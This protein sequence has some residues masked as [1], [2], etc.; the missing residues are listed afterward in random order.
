MLICGL[1]T[2]KQMYQYIDKDGIEHYTDKRPAADQEFK[3][4]PLRMPAAKPVAVRQV[5]SEDEPAWLMRNN[6]AGPIEV[7]LILEE[8]KAVVSQPELPAS[9][10]LMA[11]QEDT[12]LELFADGSGERWIFRWNYQVIPGDPGIVPNSSAVNYIPFP[13]GQAYWVSQA[14]QGQQTHL[15]KQ[16]KFA[17]DITMP[18]GTPVLA[19]RDGIVMAMEDNFFEGGQKRERYLNKANQ[20]RVLHADGTMSVYAHLKLD[21]TK[22]RKGQSVT[23]GQQLAESGNTGFSSGPHLHFAIQRNAGGKLLSLPFT[24]TRSNGTQVVPDRTLR[25]VN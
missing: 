18:E 3:S 20:I 19:V 14:F 7:Q 23:A 11:G 1:A 22:V 13:S 10:L 4:R 17:I 21:S 24:F 9:V 5:G 25:L 6:L 16:S 2:G 8:S 15:D 12:I